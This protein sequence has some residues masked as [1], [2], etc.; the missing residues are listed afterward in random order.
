MKVDNIDSYS[1]HQIFNGNPFYFG[2]PEPPISDRVEGFTWF[3]PAA[4][5][6]QPWTWNATEGIWLSSPLI[7][8]FSNNDFVISTTGD[9]TWSNQSAIF[10][11]TSSNRIFIKDIFGNLYNTGTVAHTSS[12]YYIFYL[13]RFLGS[14]Q[15]QNTVE[16]TPDSSG[17]TIPTYTTSNSLPQKPSAS[18]LRRITMRNVNLWLPGNTWYQRF[19]ATRG[20]ATTTASGVKITASLTQVLQ[21]ARLT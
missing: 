9:T 18:S 20:G 10:Y 17:M 7:N 13:D 11:S 12:L 15:L 3:E 2:N 4:I 5:F 6:P 14:D 8:T 21:L 19:R 1:P 16:I